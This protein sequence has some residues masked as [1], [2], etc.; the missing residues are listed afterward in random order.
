MGRGTGFKGADFKK[1]LNYSGEYEVEDQIDA[2][3]FS[4]NTIM[5]MQ[6]ELVFWMVVCGGFMSSNCIL[7]VRMYLKWQLLLH[8]LLIGDFMILFIP[9]SF[10]KLHKK[11]TLLV[12]MITH[13]NF[14]NLLRKYL[15]IHGSADDNVHVQTP[16]K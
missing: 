5:L 12:M 13:N 8:Q 4:E 10:Y 14:T 2:A 6:L 3:K 9:N 7:K 15:L 11:E 1:S 16:C